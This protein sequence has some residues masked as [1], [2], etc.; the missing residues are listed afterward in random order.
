[1]PEPAAAAEPH[2]SNGS[3]L[4]DE[5]PTKRL[6]IYQS[7]LSRWFSEE[8]EPEPAEAEQQ[9]ESGDRAE[10]RTGSPEEEGWQSVSDT[11]WQAAHALLEPKGRRSPP[12]ACRSACPTPTWCRVRSGR[13]AA[14]HSPT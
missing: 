14:T 11:G 5:V 7:V 10:D 12:P 2:A 4:E 3:A 1:M 13:R 6:P 9:D 8:A